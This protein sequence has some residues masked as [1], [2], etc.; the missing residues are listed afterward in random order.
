[1]PLEMNAAMT[2]VDFRCVTDISE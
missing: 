1:M 2:T